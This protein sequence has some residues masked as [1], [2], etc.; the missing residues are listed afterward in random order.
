MISYQSIIQQ[1]PPSARNIIVIVPFK[2]N[3]GDYG[4]QLGS[5]IGITFAFHILSATLI[6][7]QPYNSLT[8]H[9]H[10][11]HNWKIHQFRSNELQ[12]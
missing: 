4:E 1:I 11:H 10:P 6:Q 9:H 8:P 2:K 5:Q 12:C 3:L 7:T